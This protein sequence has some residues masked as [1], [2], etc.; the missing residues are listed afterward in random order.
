MIKQFR[1]RKSI[2]RIRLEFKL[3]TETGAEPIHEA[4]LIESD[5]NLNLIPNSL[6]DIFFNVLIESDWNLNYNTMSQDWSGDQVLIE[7]DWNL[8]SDKT[9][10][11]CRCIQ[12]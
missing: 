1:R 6:T 12:Y 9:I 4:V 7:S 11:N 5:W 8:N 2:N 10:R 3:I